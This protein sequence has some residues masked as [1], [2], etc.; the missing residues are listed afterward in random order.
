MARGL[1]PESQATVRGL[2]LLF[3]S[4]GPSHEQGFHFPSPAPPKTSLG[5]LKT[6]D[7]PIL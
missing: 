2:F 5:T 6:E 3:L 1:D 4:S 7:G